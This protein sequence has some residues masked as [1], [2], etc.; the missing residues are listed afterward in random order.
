MFILPK[1][2]FELSDYIYKAEA[3]KIQYMW[4]ER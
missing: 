3:G 2:E 4:I 1:T